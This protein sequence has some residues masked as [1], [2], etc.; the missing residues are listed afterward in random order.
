MIATNANFILSVINFCLP[1][2][3]NHSRRKGSHSLR[4]HTN[5]QT[6]T[7]KASMT[8]TADAKKE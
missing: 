8:V 1:G 7:V 3:G 5:L 6:F 2:G 4:E